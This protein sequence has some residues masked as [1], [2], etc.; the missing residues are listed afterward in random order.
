[1]ATFT[2][3]K[4]RMKKGYMGRKNPSRKLPEKGNKKFK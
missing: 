3:T 4:I 1:M 2:F